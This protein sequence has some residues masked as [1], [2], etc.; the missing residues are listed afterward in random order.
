MPAACNFDAP[1]QTHAVHMHPNPLWSY[2]AKHVEQHLSAEDQQRMREEIGEAFLSSMT[3]GSDEDV[4]R[5]I[6]AWMRTV[7]L[8]EAGVDEFLDAPDPTGPGASLDE[9][10]RRLAV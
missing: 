8:K 10:R 9:W 2:L 5:V 1:D 4:N 7:R 3:T 6:E